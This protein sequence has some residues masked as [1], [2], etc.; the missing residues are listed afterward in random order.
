MECRRIPIGPGEFIEIQGLPIEVYT[1]LSKVVAQHQRE[2]PGIT[3][4]PRRDDSTS[5][6]FI[7][8]APFL[9]RP[10]N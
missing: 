10:E 1:D 6:Q 5:K 3:D 8:L 7:R 4:H 9:R 2:K